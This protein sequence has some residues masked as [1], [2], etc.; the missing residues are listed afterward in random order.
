MINRIGGSIMAYKMIAASKDENGKAVGGIAGDQTGKE[1]W[2]YL[3]NDRRAYYYWEPLTQDI[4]DAI[5]RVAKA[6]AD[7]NNI[8]YDQ[9]PRL[10]IFYLVK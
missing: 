8:G 4:A 6:L 3:F 10:T 9:G 2:E 7:N 5:Y 1:V